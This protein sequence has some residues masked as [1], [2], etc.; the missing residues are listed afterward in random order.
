MSI[1]PTF[2]YRDARAAIDFLER[3]FGFEQHAVHRGEDGGVVHAELRY[4]DSVL[5]LG[6]VDGEHGPPPG[7]GAVYVVVTDPDAHHAR[8]VEAGA[9]VFYPL[10][11]QEYGSR[12][13]GALDPEGN[14]WSFGTYAPDLGG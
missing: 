10:T 12:D 2:H 7:A 3:A 6:A 14:R 4:G 13:Y 8:A 5:M 1:H 11:D 9:E